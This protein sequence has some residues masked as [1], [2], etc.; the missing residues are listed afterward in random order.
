MDKIKRF[1]DCHIPVETCNLRCHYCYITQHGLF[2]SKITKSNYTPEFI[3]KALSK[4]RLGGTCMFNFCAGGETLLWPELSSY[5][6]AL[7]E[8]GHYVMIVTN[9]TS[10]KGFDELIGSSQAGMERLFFKFS[11]HFLE[12]RRRNL[13]DRFFDNIKRVKDAGCAFTIEITPSDE[14]IPYIDEAKALC[15]QRFGALPHITIARDETDPDELPILTNYSKDDYAKIWKTFD[16]A[17][18]D[19][20]LSVFGIKRK[21][22]CYAG[23]WSCYLNIATGDMAQCYKSNYNYNIYKNIDA[24]IR[25]FAIGRKCREHHCYNA[26]AFLSFGVIPELQ[27]PYYSSLRNRICEDGTEWLNPTM[28]SFMNSKLNECNDEYSLF[29]QKYITCL[30]SVIIGRR[31]IRAKLGGI[32]RSAS[33]P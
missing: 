16:S 31:W 24:P 21:E 12:L 32:F 17:L 10:S 3:G 18:F 23:D 19:Y 22:F 9:G 4:E 11:Y 28:K 26:H 14:L 8:Q 27:A 1:I 7:L 5:A 6:S 29:K 25:F 2:S 30:N 33:R 15:L 13:L 20:K